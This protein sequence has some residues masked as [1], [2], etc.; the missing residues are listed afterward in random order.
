MVL[1]GGS[2]VGWAR[3]LGARLVPRPSIHKTGRPFDRSVSKFRLGV[4]LNRHSGWGGAPHPIDV[5]GGEAVGLVD[6]ISNLMF[7][8]QNLA[9][10]W[11]ADYTITNGTSRA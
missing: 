8:L 9:I 4:P 2:W 6:E 1:V 10:A 7:E 11:E 5:F 3:G